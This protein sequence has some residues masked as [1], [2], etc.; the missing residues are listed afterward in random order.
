[1]RICLIACSAQKRRSRTTAREL[2]TGDLFKKSLTW[3]STQLPMFDEVAVLSA[4]HGL[5]GLSDELDVSDGA[6]G[7]RSPDER[8]AWGR[9]V[10]EQM[11]QR[12]SVCR[13]A[14]TLT[15]LEG[16]IYV[17]PLVLH[18]QIEAPSILVDRPLAGLGIGQRKAWLMKH[19]NGE[20]I[21]C[22][23]I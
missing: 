4:R 21:S 2:R 1:M 7:Y 18:L 10:F 8:R 14:G 16:A 15:L 22:I 12:W 19:I 13:G 17:E 5:V 3:A 23:G 9:H 11:E 20:R 6:L